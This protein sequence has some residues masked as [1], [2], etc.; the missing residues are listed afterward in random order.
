VPAAL[1][2]SPEGTFL[3]A[4]I[5]QELAWKPLEREEKD[6]GAAVVV[7]PVG[8]TAGPSVWEW[9]SG[10]VL[11]IAFSPDGSWLAA[12][13][14]VQ[15][16]VAERK[17]MQARRCEGTVRLWKFPNGGTGEIFGAFWSPVTAVAFSPDGSILAVA[18]E[19]G[20]VELWK[21]SQGR[22]IASYKGHV[23]SVR[24]IAFSPDGELMATAGDD[25][26]IKLWRA[27]GGELW[28]TLGCADH[29]ISGLTFLD[30]NLLLAADWRGMLKV[31]RTEDGFLL[32]SRV[33]HDAAVASISI[34]A[35]RN[36]L[37]SVS[38][39][40]T[41]KVWDLPDVKSMRT[42]GGHGGAVDKLAFW[43]AGN[44]LVSGEKSGKTLHFRRAVDG[45]I[46]KTW[47][48]VGRPDIAIEQSESLN[49][50]VFYF[51]PVG[52]EIR[53]LAFS[54]SGAFFATGDND[55][56][57]V[58]KSIFDFEARDWFRFKGVVAALAFSP[59]GQNLACAVEDGEY[60]PFRE[61]S[62]LHLCGDQRASVAWKQE[63]ENYVWNIEFSP[64]GKL[65]ASSSYRKGIKLW[66]VDDGQF[67]G[68]IGLDS[69]SAPEV[70]A[71]SPDGRFLAA[72][73]GDLTVKVWRV[74][75]GS[76]VATLGSHNRSIKALAFSPNGKILGSAS[77]D[78]SVKLWRSSDWA[79]LS[80]IGPLEDE[81]VHSLAFSPDGKFLATGLSEGWIAVWSLASLE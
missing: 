12:G 67:V 66:R 9:G 27:Q 46:V 26:Q 53:S 81:E 47:S 54:P 49:S 4:A 31:Y 35:A 22:C 17:I 7:W 78:G 3:A 30:N 29:V 72:A 41:M 24:T 21:F 61:I 64:D 62:L 40:Y 8:Q 75:D 38:D 33:A 23:G 79:L 14:C 15:R 37:V 50:E 43:P 80:T 18:T 52:V 60:N 68:T 2:F 42:L 56:V 77:L 69:S 44:V 13:G 39:D 20:T 10:A 1:A 25:R 65:L 58:I 76:L 11:S 57:I 74:A 59:D 28:K 6:L 55:G 19:N 48:G 70:F 36:L 16:P 71:F 5:N 51:E 34:S 63:Y 32:F 73:M 45:E